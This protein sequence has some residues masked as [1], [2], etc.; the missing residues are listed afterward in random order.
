MYL[1]A[2]YSKELKNDIAIWVG[3]AVFKVM[4]QN[5]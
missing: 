4:D 3:Q 2:N 5:S 1:K